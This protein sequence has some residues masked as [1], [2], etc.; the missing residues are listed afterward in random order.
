MHHFLIEFIT[1]GGMANQ[2]LPY[3]LKKEGDLM[4]R[5]LINELVDAGN[6]EISIVRDERLK[7]VN[8]NI[9]QFI[10]N[11]SLVQEL[12]NYEI[13]SDFIWL[14][15]PETDDCL[16]S[17]TELFKEHGRIFTGCSVE[18]VKLTASKISC[19]RHLTK[20]NINTIE[21]YNLNEE[22]P[23][24]AQG[25]VIKPDDG[26][27]GEDCT[28]IETK[29]QLQQIKQD[30]TAT[31]Y[32]VQPYISGESLSMSL[33]VYKNDVRLLG[34]N[35]QLISLIDNKFKFEGVGV[36]ECLEYQNEFLA[37]AKLIVEAIPGLSG[38]VGIDLIYTDNIFYIV[39]INP[40]FTTAYVGLSKSIGVNVAEFIV[41]VFL[42]DMLP[43][44]QL[45]SAIP[46]RI[47][48]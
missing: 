11:N 13:N 5:T 48:V 12:K 20:K 41:N 1:G 43:E 6:H 27:G 7:L 37:I 3:A 17:L 35:R 18:A 19:F 46:V 15:A 14:I 47:Q 34:C 9:T 32:V 39:D 40:R 16:A 2:G 45:S 25:Y 30:K 44:I 22:T 31:N 24:F 8:E 26:V 33:L 21:T 4:L 29:N 10:I 23:I 28:Y 38:F 42:E 36:N